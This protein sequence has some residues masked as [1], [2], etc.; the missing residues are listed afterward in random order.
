MHFSA[1]YNTDCGNVSTGVE[2]S[3]S[4]KFGCSGTVKYSNYEELPGYALKLIVSTISSNSGK[5]SAD[6]R[7]TFC[8][9]T[10]LPSV[11]AFA[12]S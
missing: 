12:N 7:C 3:R 1:A 5:K 11:V 2:E 8:K 9:N 4:L 6:A 10:Q